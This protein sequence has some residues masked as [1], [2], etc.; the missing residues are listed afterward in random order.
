MKWRNDASLDDLVVRSRMF[1]EMIDGRGDGS[2]SNRYECLD[3]ARNLKR[4]M[5]FIYIYICKM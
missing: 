4:I 2:G 3:D 5:I 1:F